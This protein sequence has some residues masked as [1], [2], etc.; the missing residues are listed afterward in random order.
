MEFQTRTIGH[1]RSLLRQETEPVFLLGAGASVKSGVPTSNAIFEKI[2][3]F[4]YC[5][6]KGISPENPET[7]RS[8]W[9]P[10][11]RRPYMV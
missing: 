6:E 10:W 11:L 7:R 5:L 8:D 9:H 2:A 1:L 4:G 3:K